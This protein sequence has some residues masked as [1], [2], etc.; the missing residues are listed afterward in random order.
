MRK[1]RIRSLLLAANLLLLALPLGGLWMLR[2]YESAL[3]RQ[4][5]SELVA[6]GAVIAA[7]YRAAWRGL[8][9]PPLPAERDWAPRG[10]SLDLARDPVLPAPPE[11]LP[12]M[13]PPEP[14]AQR[15]GALL[16]SVLAETQLVTLAAMRVM[17][18]HGTVVATSREELG[19]SL[20]A[21]QE[22]ALALAGH[23]A[24]ALRARVPTRSVP[25]S[26]SSISRGA[27]LRVFVVQPVLEQG[28]VIGAVLL[29]RTPATLD[30]ILWG[31]RVEIGGL[32]LAVLLAAGALALF[33]AYTVG[34]PIQA[35]AAQARAVAAGARVPMDRTRRSAVRE[36][37]ELWA[38][39]TAMATTLEQ[40]A[41]Y[42]GAFAAEVSHEFKTPLTALRG[43]LEL[44]QEHGASMTE[45]E[46]ERFLAQAMG[47][48]LRL[49]RLVRR[50]LELAR[51]EAPQPR[52][53]ER[54]EFASTIAAIVAPYAEAGL[55]V[56]L[57]GPAAEVAIGRDMLREVLANLLDNIRQHAGPEAA[58]RI[59]WGLDAGPGRIGILVAD[60]GRGVTNGN[61]GRIFDR[62]FTTARKVG[63]TGLGLPIVRSR[64]EA[65]G[66]QIRL[67]P[68]GPGARFLITLP[69]A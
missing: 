18:R 28:Q 12:P 57:E 59:Q 47:D 45:A 39:I 46:R 52:A 24:A 38:A 69:R 33:I 15:A 4:T 55:K 37:D 43:G 16:Q 7:A 32:V 49:D 60:D 44:L 42:I 9:A 48:V 51:A 31:K 67:L 64:L 50:L 22:V 29:S 41:D 61:A 8:P 2:L 34:R 65:V 10:A 14:Q 27:A 56:T 62:F 53:P 6:Q 17:D 58:C 26:P 54:C 68:D 35:V 3:V 63:G 19:L 20:A 13:Q 40:R 23:P 5:E 36:A 21:Q 30:Q 1:P 25:T 66:G 11:A